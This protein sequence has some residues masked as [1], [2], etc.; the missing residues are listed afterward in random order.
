MTSYSRRRIFA[1]YIETGS[2][3]YYSSYSEGKAVLSWG[4]AGRRS[5][6][7]APSGSE[8]K[9]KAISNGVKGNIFTLR[10]LLTKYVRNLS[11][12]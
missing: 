5:F 7:Y 1:L 4:T 9:N 2:R 12:L 11:L 6:D 10:S 8:T 3:L